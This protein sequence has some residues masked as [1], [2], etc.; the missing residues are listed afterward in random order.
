MNNGDTAWVLTSSAFVFIMLPGLA[1]FYG[2]LVRNKNVLATIMHSFIALAII[3]IVWVLW[4]YSLA[5]GPSWEGIIGSLEWFGLQGVS[6]TATGPYSDTIPHQAFMIFQAKFAI[7]TPALI[8]G[9]FAERIKFKAFVLF[10]ILWSTLVYA[11]AAHWMWGAG[12]WLADWGAKDFAGGAVVH[13]TSGI[14]AISAALVLGKRIGLGKES[15][16]PHNISYIVLG[17]ALLWFGWFGFNG[18]SALAANGTAVSA[19]VVTHIS[20]AVAT[21]T[22]VMIDWFL[23]GKPS[24]VG[25]ATGAIAGL[26]TITP[27]AGFVGP[28]PAILI[29]LAAGALCY[30]AVYVKNRIQLDDSLDVFAVHGMG[31]IIGLISVALLGGI[32]FMSL[33]E[34]TDLSRGEFLIRQLGAIGAIAA[35]SFGITTIIL[36]ALKTTIG[37][38]VTS[39]EE[40]MGLDLSEHGETA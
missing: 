18:G 7:I 1:F 37:L 4:G 40:E 11:P 34:I 6:A 10:I 35:W 22:W 20:A 39:E 21:V 30:A 38:R 19:F 16:E 28:M 31:G 25:A 29:G 32:G 33:A 14:A 12:G 5:F 8:A 24:V 3:G 36:L 26:A 27:A 13:L 17:A 15:M 23:K 2:G 9:A